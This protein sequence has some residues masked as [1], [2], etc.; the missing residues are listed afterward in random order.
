MTVAGTPH[1]HACVR[2]RPGFN[3]LE[4]PPEVLAATGLNLRTVPIVTYR[5]FSVGIPLGPTWPSPASP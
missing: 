5:T 4:K 2:T 3:G 1:M